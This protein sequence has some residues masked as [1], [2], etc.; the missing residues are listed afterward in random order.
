MTTIKQ[1]KIIGDIHI[2]EDKKDFDKFLENKKPSTQKRYKEYRVRGR[3]LRAEGY[4]FRYDKETKTYIYTKKGIQPTE[5]KKK[6]FKIDVNQHYV[7]GYLFRCDY[8]GSEFE[9][10]Y[11]YSD[12][13]EPSDRITLR[14]HSILFP[15]HN[16]KEYEYLGSKVVKD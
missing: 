14:R 15:E 11:H 8:A 3:E 9:H 7:H 10:T 12:K 16:L 13:K 4:N 1:H 5:L 6:K 2:F